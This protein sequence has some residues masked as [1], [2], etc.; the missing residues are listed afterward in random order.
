MNR[1]SA[2]PTLHADRYTGVAAVTSYVTMKSLPA[3]V[4]GRPSSR[5]FDHGHR[6][7]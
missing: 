7:P 3:A 6:A 1:E 5:R 4:E 2:Q